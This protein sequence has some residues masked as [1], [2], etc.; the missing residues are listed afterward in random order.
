MENKINN[1]KVKFQS[2][3]IFKTNET[4]V[5]DTMPLYTVVVL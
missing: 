3:N 4:L 5:V 1:F 2:K